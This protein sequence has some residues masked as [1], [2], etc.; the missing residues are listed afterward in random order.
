MAEA[1]RLVVWDLDE[2]FWKGTL[3]EGGIREYVIEHHNI[4]IELAKR[5]IVSSICSK[6]DRDVVLKILEEQG[7][8]DYFVFSSISW[9][10]KGLR[11]AQLVSAVQL[12]ATTV[13]FIDDNPNN[14]GEAQAAV[15]G[16]QVESE[17][18][19]PLMLS[20]PRFKGKSDSDLSRL[21]QYQLLDRR[22]SDE[23]S[24]AGSNEDF[25]RKCDIRVLIENDVD[26][27]LDRAVELINRTNQLNYTKLRLPEDPEQARRTLQ[28]DLG[29]FGCNAGLIRV[30]DKY[31]DYGFVGFFLMVDSDKAHV[32]GALSRLMYFCF[33]C[34]TLGMLVEQWVYEHLGQ[35]E[36]EVVGEVLTDL[37]VPRNIDWIRQVASRV[38]GWM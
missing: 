37:S 11:L 1:V 2:T 25:L 24:A 13:M 28:A 15:P 6:N 29:L 27:H 21:K 30:K 9:Q 5:G 18:F 12:R 22:Q 35:P 16:L 34:R 19:I 31:G 4:V 23:Q 3:T 10:P 33:S 36:I 14:L 20:D 7:I 32:S 17:K 38:L 8:Q 26:T